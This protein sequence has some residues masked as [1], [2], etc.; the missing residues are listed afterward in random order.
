MAFNRISE[1]PIESRE[2]IHSPDILIV[3]DPTLLRIL[4]IKVRKNGLA[5]INS[6]K[7]LSELKPIFNESK[8]AVVNATKIAMEIFGMPLTNAPMMGAFIRAANLVK[9]SSVLEVVRE[10]FPAAAEKDE[11]AIRSAF[12]EVVIE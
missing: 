8:I 7:S 10:K 2:Q 6:R 12:D 3:L 9:I 1:T 11:R 4:Q 5:I